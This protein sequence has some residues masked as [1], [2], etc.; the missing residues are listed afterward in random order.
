MMGAGVA[1]GRGN[2]S[3]YVAGFFPFPMSAPPTFVVRTR[4]AAPRFHGDSEDY[5]GL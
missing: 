4:E 3:S 1:P 5:T 2:M